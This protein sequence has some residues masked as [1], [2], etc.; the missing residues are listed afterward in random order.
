MIQVVITDFSLSYSPKKYSYKKK[1]CSILIHRINGRTLNLLI[2]GALF[3]Y[4][5]E[6]FLF[7]QKVQDSC[8]RNY[9]E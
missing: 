5:V 4:E 6:P 1:I 3:Q 9:C 7:E 8:R 2:G